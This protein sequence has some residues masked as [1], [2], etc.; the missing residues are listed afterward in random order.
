ME[1]EAMNRG[2][3]P[4]V[5]GGTSTQIPM[6]QMQ[7]INR[8][9][10]SLGGHE[11]GSHTIS[12]Y[13]GSIRKYPKTQDIGVRASIV[14]MGADG[15]SN[16]QFA[17]VYLYPPVQKNPVL[18]YRRLSDLE[19]ADTLVTIVTERLGDKPKTKIIHDFLT[20]H[21]AMAGG[22]MKLLQQVGM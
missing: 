21:P 22:I 15:D 10:G 2:M 16:Q 4:P 13:Y 6:C 8:E 18:G 9:V 5:L 3:L 20:D 12:S 1:N 11:D 17:E 7:Q 19:R 14:A